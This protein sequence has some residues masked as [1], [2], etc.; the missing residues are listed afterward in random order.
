MLPC[1]VHCS[2]ME[3]ETT[4]PPLCVTASVETLELY[5]SSLNLR[6]DMKVRVVCTM[7]SFY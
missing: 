7:A 6:Q 3:G 1:L 4:R 2:E 5:S